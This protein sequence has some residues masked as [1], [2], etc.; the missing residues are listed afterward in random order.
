MKRDSPILKFVAL[1]LACCGAKWFAPSRNDGAVV[2]VESY[3]TASAPTITPQQE[4]SCES[5]FQT[6]FPTSGDLDSISLAVHRNGEPA[7]CGEATVQN[8]IQQLK[9]NFQSLECPDK[10]DKYVFEALLTE[11]LNLVLSG[12]CESE[13][14]YGI[15]ALGF[16]GY[17]DGGEE[18]TP[19]LLDHDDLVPV[20][21]NEGQSESLPCHFHNR[22]GLRIT[23]PH[24]FS[25]WIA[26]IQNEPT[27]QDCEGDETTQTC[28]AVAKGIH[29]YAVP[30]GRVF[31]FAPSYVGEVFHLPHVQGASDKPIHLEVISLEPRVF[32]VF[33]FFN[34]EESKE[35]VDRAI[36]ETSETHRIK[37]STTG[38]GD[39]AV[40]SRRT[41]E[42]GFDTNGKTALKIKKWVVSFFCHSS[43]ISS[44]SIFFWCDDSTMSNHFSFIL[45]ALIGAASMH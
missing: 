7:P 5:R 30:A 33:N 1:L 34:R 6:L 41:S 23:Q 3:E 31:M 2:F 27:E 17:C 13:E 12:E 32:D 38:A 24:Q 45:A 42:S 28:V 14:E 4:D 29:F 10:L 35:L 25:D 43:C 40:N 22:E 39:K 8:L 11:S 18:H 15:P 37:R 19:I 9:E 16:L 20:L 21:S 26:E 36:A 44:E